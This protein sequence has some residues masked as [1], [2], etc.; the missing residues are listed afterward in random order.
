M[1]KEFVQVIEQLLC[2]KTGKAIAVRHTCPVGGGCINRTYRIETTAGSFFVKVNDAGRYPGMFHAEEKGLMMMRQTN[3]IAVPEVVG[4]G[5][6]EDQ[7]FLILQWIESARRQADFFED[8]AIRLAAMHRHSST[9]YGLDHDN[10]IGSLP[11]VNTLSS[12]F[13][14]FFIC[15]RLETQLKEAIHQHR[16]SV[17]IHRQFE[18]LYRRFSEIIPP[19]KPAFIHGDLWSGNYM[20]GADG[21]VCLIDPA[22]YY[23]HRESDIAMSLLFG[24]FDRDF[25]DVYNHHFPMESGWRQ[26][27][28]VL[29]LYPLL[30]H[31]NLFGG[32]YASQVMQIVKRF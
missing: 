13:E 18:K 22:V 11:Q 26:R 17:N 4:R 14:E 16:L 28:D 31:V 1:E 5:E 9:H 12:S 29:N 20:T 7:A 2:Q 19:E 6:H 24:G 15:Y 3:T 30:V 25:Y 8:F 27:A 23:G 21:Y 32:G 10:Y